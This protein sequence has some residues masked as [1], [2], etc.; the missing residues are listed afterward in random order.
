MSRS[1]PACEMGSCAVSCEMPMNEPRC[2][3]HPGDYLRAAF[4]SSRTTAPTPR[5][6]SSPARRLPASEAGTPQEQ[7]DCK[8]SCNDDFG[9]D[10]RKDE[11]KL[12]LDER[13]EVLRPYQLLV[14]LRGSPLARQCDSA[15]DPRCDPCSPATWRR[16]SRPHPGTTTPR[17]ALRRPAVR[18]PDPDQT[19]AAVA[20]RRDHEATRFLGGVAFVVER[21]LRATPGLA[22]RTSG[23]LVGGLDAHP[24]DLHHRGRLLG[25][26]ATWPRTIHSSSSVGEGLLHYPPLRIALVDARVMS[27]ARRRVPQRRSGCRR[28]RQRPLPPRGVPR[29]PRV[30]AVHPHRPRRGRSLTRAARPRW[31]EAGP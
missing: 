22:A 15:D 21:R 16:W 18:V 31:R 27:G 13:D 5:P 12:W 30:L 20:V 3:L 14:P 8:I 24:V 2:R 23:L 9:N 28:P 26:G 7:A 29:A 25:V 11:F 4:A 17:V 19:P 10:S 1:P 6:C